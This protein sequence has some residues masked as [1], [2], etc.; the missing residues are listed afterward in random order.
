MYTKDIIMATMD[1]T[2]TEVATLARVPPPVYLNVVAPFMALP[3]AFMPKVVT[4]RTRTAIKQVHI[5]DLVPMWQI[6]KD[7]MNLQ[8]ALA[9]LR[10]S[11]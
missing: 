2:A 6:V 5:L 3:R 10:T 9:P 4:G 8:P 7:R 11:P 1:L